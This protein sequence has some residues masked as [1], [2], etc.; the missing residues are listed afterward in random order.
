MSDLLKRAIK[1]KLS[2]CV[3]VFGIL[4]VLH[5]LHQLINFSHYE[6]Y[7]FLFK[8]LPENMILLR[9][10]FSMFIRLLSLV[11][12]MGIL[13]RKEFFRKA[14]VFICFFQFSPSTGSIPFLFLKML[15]TLCQ[16]KVC[17]QV[18]S[19]KDLNC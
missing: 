10:S 4:I 6:K 13:L 1:N 12:G 9:Y 17:C 8:H 11:S 19:W 16:N 18:Y 15:L 5:A 2:I 14:M 3:S 7:L